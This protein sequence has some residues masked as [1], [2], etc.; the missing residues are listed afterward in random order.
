MSKDEAENR[1]SDQ[2]HPGIQEIFVKK[3]RDGQGSKGDKYGL[4]DGRDDKHIRWF[5]RIV[6]KAEL[7]HEVV[8]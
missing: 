5:T 3:N 8:V 1:K 4:C 2:E 7:A 6:V